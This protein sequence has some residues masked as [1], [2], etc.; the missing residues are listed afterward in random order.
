[1]VFYA[2]IKY[3]ERPVPV[4]LHNG[5]NVQYTTFFLY[6]SSTFFII[7]TFSYF[8]VPWGDLRY[9][10]DPGRSLEDPR[11]DQGWPGGPWAIYEL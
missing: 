8:W 3:V 10:E 5:L 1:M 9:P 4:I 11:G 7:F 2:Y 6:K